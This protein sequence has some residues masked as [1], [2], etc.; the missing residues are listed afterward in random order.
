MTH[1]GKNISFSF[2]D[3]TDTHNKLRKTHS[4]TF[5]LPIYTYEY[6]KNIQDTEPPSKHCLL[7]NV[8]ERRLC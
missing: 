2:V 8:W 7:Y 6:C 4:D 1:K 3:L 5:S